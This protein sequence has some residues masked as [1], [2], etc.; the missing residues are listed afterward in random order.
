MKNPP[1]RRLRPLATLAIVAVI[2]VIATL[3]IAAYSTAQQT[4]DTA[5][6]APDRDVTI[7]DPPADQ[8]FSADSGYLPFGG[9]VSP[10]DEQLPIIA[11]LDPALRAALQD[12]ATAASDDGVE[13]VVTSGWRSAEYQQALLDDAV[14]KYGSLVEA[15]KWVS[16][17]ELSA[18][19]TGDAVDVGY[20]DADSWL[21]QHG[22]DYGLCQIYANEMWHFELA[23]RPGGFCP[24]QRQDAAG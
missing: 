7:P 13:M 3:G 12:A 11:N 8:P 4:V 10:F 9:T 5:V 15:R 24:A 19:V 22:D 21:S 6:G 20:T 14:K 18:H 1:R 16:T 23:T 2:A 17:P